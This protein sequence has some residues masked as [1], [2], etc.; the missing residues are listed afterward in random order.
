MAI[1]KII[2]YKIATFD[3][4]MTIQILNNIKQYVTL[5]ATEEKAFTDILEIKQLK[6]K[7]FLLQ[8]GKT[9]DKIYFINKGCLR[10]FHVNDVHINNCNENTL[11][12]LFANTWYTDFQ[13]FLLNQPTDENVQALEKSEIVQFSIK[14]L[15]N[16]YLIYPVFER[17]GR[18]LIQNALIS[19]TNLN[20]EI[21]N[22][23]PSERYLKI[24]NQ[25]PEIVQQIPQYY[26]AEFLGIKRESLSRIK[27]RILKQ[28]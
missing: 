11:E 10:L 21:V 12:F 24:L 2:S 19:L 27:K 25:Q 5:N 16:L 15:D 7:E 18:L 14:D 4:K 9:C 22:E 8:E 6:K 3:N 26:I 20:K 17:M 28:L 13:S 1:L 23:T